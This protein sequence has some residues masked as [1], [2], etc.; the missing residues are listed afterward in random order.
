[1]VL[2]FIVLSSITLAIDNPLDDP[3]SNGKMLL[4]YIDM[5]FTVTF[6]LEALIKIIAKSLLFADL[7][8]KPYL[9]NSWNMLDAFVVIVSL[10]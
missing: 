4:T 5:F 9:L 2:V 6:I 3:N 8:I 10:V 1:M 7:P